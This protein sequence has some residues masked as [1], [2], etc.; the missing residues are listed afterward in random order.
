MSTQLNKLLLSNRNLIFK[1]GRSVSFEQK[2]RLK[3]QGFRSRKIRLCASGIEELVQGEALQ[4]AIRIHPVPKDFQYSFARSPRFK[5]NLEDAINDQIN[6]EY[7]ISYIYHSMYAFFS[8]D[9]VALDGFA[10]LFKKES[11][12]ERLH[13]ELLMDY[14]TKRGGKVFLQ[15]IMPPQLEF[16]HAQKG[17]GLY[18]LELALSLEKLNYDKLL[19]LHEVADECGDAAACDFIEGELL[20]SQVDSVKESAALV[21]TLTRMGA[22]GPYGGLAT[23]HFDKNL[24][25]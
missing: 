9:N 2:L 16:E 21:A 17:C 13:A 20:E 15:A 12:E 4:E 6:I 8:R 10:Q 14:Q 23:W 22:N 19:Y 25:N 11:L 24:Q 18:A 7:N 3:S 1:D 5:Q